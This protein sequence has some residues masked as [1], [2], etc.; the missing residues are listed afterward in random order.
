[1]QRTFNPLNSERYRSGPPSQTSQRSSRFHKPAPPRASLGSAT[2]FCKPRG[3]TGVRPGSHSARLQPV[4]V[5][6]SLGCFN[7]LTRARDCNKDASIRSPRPNY[8]YGLQALQRC[9]G[10][11]N[12]RARGSTV[13]THH[14]PRPIRCCSSATAGPRRQKRD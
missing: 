2:T 10:L 3:P 11:L 6:L 7:H 12:R 9:S 5:R 13:A 4:Q 1:M 8:F 14:F